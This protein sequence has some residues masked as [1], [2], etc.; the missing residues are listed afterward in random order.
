MPSE[1]TMEIGPPKVQRGDR[2]ATSLGLTPV[3]NS[4]EQA[5]EALRE[6]AFLELHAATVEAQAR[7]ERSVIEH[8][9]EA[10]ASFEIEGESVRGKDR[11]FA[12]E[13]ALQSYADKKCPE[14]QKADGK[15]AKRSMK[16]AAGTI[17]WKKAKDSVQ[18]C[19]GKTETDV[20]AALEK[21][22]GGRKGKGI[23]SKIRGVI[24]HVLLFAADKRRR[25]VALMFDVRI[26]LN[27]TRALNAFTNDTIDKSELRK[28]GLKFVPGEDEFYVKPDDFSLS[29]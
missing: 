3:I 18:I 7:R 15:S 5:S 28:L 11:R 21:S 10:E 2:P 23:M 24:E 4:E 12:L 27:R 25:A 8:W 29:P 13:G 6:L 17:G 16:L 1:T 14:L 9:A 26:T 19:E 20:I 22:S